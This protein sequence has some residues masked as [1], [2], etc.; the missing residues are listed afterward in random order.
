LGASLLVI[1]D[2]AA[3][4][5]GLELT[6]QAA[7]YRV[8][9]APTGELG[10]TLT[11]REPVALVLLDIMLPGRS[12]LDVCRALRARG[13]DVP[14]ILVSARGTEADVVRGLEAGA[15]DYVVKPFRSGE[16]LARIAAQL[17]RRPPTDVFRF[18]EV[19]IDVGRR[20]VVRD[21]VAVELSPTEFD[22][23]VLFVRRAGDVL[24]R[25]TI[26]AAVWGEGYEGTDRTVDNF[27]TRLRQKFDAAGQP[28]RFLTV[29]GV[30]YRFEP[31]GETP[32]RT[33]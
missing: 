5:R 26:L 10:L 15:D 30:G 7:G 2:D 23:L 9:G 11:E 17:R 3:I 24:T 19:E 12:G 22:L 18:D 8:L 1:E 13:L 31:S 6:L 32:P 33:P 21:N 20:T 29:R 27:V 16:L 28:P 4:R 25:D 14:I